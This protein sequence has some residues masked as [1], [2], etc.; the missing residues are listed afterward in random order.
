MGYGLTVENTAESTGGE[1]A[2]SDERF[3][4]RI[5]AAPESL[6]IAGPT[7]AYEEL[8]KAVRQDIADV[9]VYVETPLEEIGSSALETIVTA[10]GETPAETDEG[11][12]Q[13][14]AEFLSPSNVHV[15][16]V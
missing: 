10:L 6:S 3:K 4:E 15:C 9:A 5:Y 13:I 2:E 8:V 7:T 12:R 14:I 11:N 1:D 16:L